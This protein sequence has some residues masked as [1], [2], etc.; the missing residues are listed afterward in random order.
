MAT[1]DYALILKFSK[2]LKC[3][4]IWRGLEVVQ[5]IS[6]PALHIV[7][8]ILFLTQPLWRYYRCVPQIQAFKKKRSV[9]YSSL[10]QY[11][12]GHASGRI[13]PRS[14]LLQEKTGVQ[15][16]LPYSSTSLSRRDKQLLD[17][18]AQAGDL[19]IL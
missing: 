7:S 8:L 18:L 12:E 16:F 15:V 9:D 14:T 17:R 4:F 13:M 11:K 2:T 19:F 1:H 5:S 10:L 3:D 6:T